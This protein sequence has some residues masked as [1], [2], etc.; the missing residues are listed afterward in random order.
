M[1]LRSDV[2]KIGKMMTTKY[3]QDNDGIVHITDES[4]DGEFTFCSREFGISDGDFGE[5]S[6]RMVS[7]PANCAQCSKVIIQ[8]RKSIKGARWATTLKDCLDD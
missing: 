5:F 6:G 8:V 2:T 3:V 7:G 1:I 4:G